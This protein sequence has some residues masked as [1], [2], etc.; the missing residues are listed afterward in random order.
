MKRDKT[1]TPLPGRKRRALKYLAYAALAVLLVNYTLHVGLL[2]PVQALRAVEE[3]EGVHGRTI[4]W[5]W[6]PK[7]HRTG[8]FFLTENENMVLLGYVYLGMLGWNPGFG[9][10]LDCAGDQALYAAESASYRDGGETV[11]HY[12]GRVKDPAIETVEIRLRYITGYDE[13]AGGNVYEEH[14]RLL[15]GREEWLERE[16]RQYFL[17][18]CQLEDWPEDSGVYAFALGLDGAGNVVAEIPVEMGVHSYY[19]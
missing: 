8:L 2:L 15:A 6:E 3:R 10:A 14:S 11:R 17:L 19:G 16:G 4:D 5:Q 1:R 18:R 13:A 12:Y 7:V 9:W